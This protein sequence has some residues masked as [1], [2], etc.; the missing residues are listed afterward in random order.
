M[1]GSCGLGDVFGCRDD[2]CDDDWSPPSAICVILRMIW[3]FNKHRLF[4]FCLQVFDGILLTID[5]SGR[6]DDD[7]AAAVTEGCV[8][9]E[10]GDWFLLFDDLEFVGPGLFG[11]FNQR[12]KSP[13]R[14]AG[15]G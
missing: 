4:A 5:K 6:A 9:G 1:E 10:E 15:A 13:G 12:D 8:V 7:P 2:G 3:I 14:L 11:W